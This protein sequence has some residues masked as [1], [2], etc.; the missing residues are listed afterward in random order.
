MPAHAGENILKF[1]LH[2]RNDNAITVIRMVQVPAAPQ[3]YRVWL[4]RHSLPESTNPL[5][6]SDHD[7]IPDLLECAFGMNPS[8][9][10]Y[11]SNNHEFEA[12]PLD[13]NDRWAANFTYH[14]LP[15]I[16]RNL[17]GR[18]EAG[19]WEPARA[20]LIGMTYIPEVSTD[21]VLWT[22]VLSPITRLE[23]SLSSHSRLW[24]TVTEDGPAGAAAKW[25]RV[26]VALL[27]GTR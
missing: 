22:P 18:L 9:F 16:R 23:P 17:D 6:D 26:R 25:M 21:M 4:V 14:G 10:P 7:G 15:R 1:Q 12:L 3:A 19:W 13:L 2:D 27:P 8:T 24:S 20:D 11:A 5:A